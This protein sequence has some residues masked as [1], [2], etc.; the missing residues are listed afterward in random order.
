[1]LCVL[2]EYPLNVAVSCEQTINNRV[3]GGIVPLIANQGDRSK[4]DLVV[5][6]RNS[7]W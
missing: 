5:K 7:I 6:E 4:P 3:T 2:G 1:M